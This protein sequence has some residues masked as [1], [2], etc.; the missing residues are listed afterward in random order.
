MREEE[1]IAAGISRAL[2]RGQNVEQ[3]AKSFI[4]ANYSRTAVAAAVNLVKQQKM[5]I[6]FSQ[7]QS[8][9]DL[10]KPSEKKSN[11]GVIIAIVFLLAMVAAAI[12]AYFFV[13]K[14]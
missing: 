7:S 4:N 3:A 10:P 8:T 13:L 14:K 12:V 6:S 5:L 1:V 9:Q 2:E 11:V